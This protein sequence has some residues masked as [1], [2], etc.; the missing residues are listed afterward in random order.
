MLIVIK[1]ERKPAEDA[2]I[3]CPPG[4]ARFNPTLVRLRQ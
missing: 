4:G 2:P 3:P 1:Q